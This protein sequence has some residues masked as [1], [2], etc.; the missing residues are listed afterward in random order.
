MN[1]VGLGMDTLVRK[2]YPTDVSDN[3]WALAAPYLTLM[4]SEDWLNHAHLRMTDTAALRAMAFNTIPRPSSLHL[5]S[6]KCAWQR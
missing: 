1:L 5:C 4:T 3:E 2:P 6:G